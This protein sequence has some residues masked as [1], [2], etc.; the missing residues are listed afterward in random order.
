MGL[1][2]PKW[3]TDKNKTA[4]LEDEQKLKKA[5]EESGSPDV[6][7]TAVQKIRDS[8]YLYEQLRSIENDELVR[9]IVNRIGELDR[10]KLIKAVYDFSNNLCIKPLQEV[11]RSELSDQEL[12]E[13]LQ[14]MRYDD[15]MA[16]WIV[17]GFEDLNTIKEL[18]FQMIDEK[19]RFTDKARWEI[20]TFSVDKIKGNKD[21]SLAV[22]KELGL[23][24][25]Y[26]GDEKGL[27]ENITDEELLNS[28]ET[29]RFVRDKK[30]VENLLLDNTSDLER[31]RKAL[32]YA[33]DNQDVLKALLLDRAADPKLRMESIRYIKDKDI[34]LDVLKEPEL[35][36]FVRKEAVART[37][38][39]ETL[40]RMIKSREY[41][42]AIKSYIL[43]N[44]TFPQ[45][46]Y[47]NLVWKNKDST[48]R[49]AAL[50]MLKDREEL[51]KIRDEIGD[52]ELKVRACSRL[53]HSYELIRREE[54]RPRHG[55][56]YRS[57]IFY[58]C[59]VCGYEHAEVYEHDD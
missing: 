5:Y 31:R 25:Q 38:D 49:S 11:I 56:G 34:M 10:K 47:I 9:V 24:E 2:T 8:D 22:L 6:R 45:E 20:W 59:K 46:Y 21:L 19:L 57:S 3:M 54:E 13:A 52:E 32:Y 18:L 29:I 39:M 7:L 58:K 43:C 30:A 55:K 36:Y 12:L 41:P 14:Q 26:L 35:D 44:K 40:K 23:K 28:S 37:E 51:Q 27:L 1:F 48:V 33:K 42:S 53:G 16:I 17:K 50:D 15:M 4:L